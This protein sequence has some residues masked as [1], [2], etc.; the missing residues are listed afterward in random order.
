MLEILQ[1]LVASTELP[2]SILRGALPDL[3]RVFAKISNEAW[4]AELITAEAKAMIQSLSFESSLIGSACECIQDA[5]AVGR[6]TDS[7][8]RLSS[9]TDFRW[10]C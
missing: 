7:F 6:Q 2:R 3:R 5:L 8:L 4:A 10:P 9:S 1:G